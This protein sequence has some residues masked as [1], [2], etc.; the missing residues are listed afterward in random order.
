VKEL[1][2]EPTVP[3][4]RKRTMAGFPSE[5][6]AITVPDMQGGGSMTGLPPETLVRKGTKGELPLLVILV[7]HGETVWNS[8]GRYQGRAD[9]P[10]TEKGLKHAHNIAA[11]LKRYRADAI[12]SSPL[13]RAHTT[14]EIIAAEQGC[15]VVPDP[16][17]MEVDYG[18][19]EGKNLEE[20]EKKFPEEL[21]KK[22]ADRYNYA[23]PEGE[24]YREMNEKR[25]MPFVKKSIEPLN[26][27][28]KT[29][30]VVSH[31]GSGRMVAGNI[32]GLKG[33][34]M[35]RMWHP[36]DCVY[37]IRFAEK[38]RPH[39]SY[40]RTDSGKGDEGYLTVEDMKAQGR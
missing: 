28:C 20:I 23:H 17:L 6:S 1:P 39:I 26:G 5:S 31:S 36:N 38:G 7:R 10:L 34:E 40:F 35:M 27:S 16:L 4:S 15:E 29:I 21:A 3:D 18:F 25:I 24:A 14:A 19:F 13:G 2:S 33:E 37:F 8:E 12:Y 32:L 30:V 9:S 11:Y 22:K